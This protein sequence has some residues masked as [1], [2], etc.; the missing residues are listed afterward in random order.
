MTLNQL[1]K[2]FPTEESCRQY[3]METRW[4]GGEV[5]CPRCRKTKKVYALKAR[6]FH[7]VC[8]NESE[9]CPGVYRF[10]VLTGTIYE[11]TNVPLRL[12]FKVIYLMTVSK[13]GISALQVRRMLDPVR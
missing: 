6:P 9:E 7:W 13:K 10:S 3:L 11:N 8:K 5:V 1:E 4:P 12:W 2:R